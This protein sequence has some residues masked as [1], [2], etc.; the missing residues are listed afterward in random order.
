ML[1]SR[2]VKV[3]LV[4]SVF[5]LSAIPLVAQVQNVPV[6]TFEDIPIGTPAEAIDLPGVAFLSIPRGAFVV[7]DRASLG[8]GSGRALARVTL[9]NSPSAELHVRFSVPAKAVSFTW[10]GKGSGI[11]LGG[12][13][14]LGLS[15]GYH[16]S[17][18]ARELNEDVAHPPDGY[19]SR[20]VSWS[21]VGDIYTAYTKAFHYGPTNV[22]AVDDVVVEPKF[23]PGTCVCNGNG[24]ECFV[25]A[26]LAAPLSV[27]AGETIPITWRPYAFAFEYGVYLMPQWRILMRAS[28]DQRLV[29]RKEL[30]PIEAQGS[31]GLP[32]QM[33]TSITFPVSATDYIAELEIGQVDQCNNRGGGYSL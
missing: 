2:S 23:V 19:S 4:V 26:T 5:G 10:L 25:G 17:Q 18:S 28:P 9:I 27:R 32:P 8:I 29:Y 22:V 16:S 21:N 13:Q 15:R 33:T 31:D 11:L 14:L 7:A 20:L 1:K 30:R 3:L 12:M 6:V 24:G